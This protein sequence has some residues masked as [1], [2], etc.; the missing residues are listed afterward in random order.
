M[1]YLFDP[2]IKLS[3]FSSVFFKYCFICVTFFFSAPRPEQV[4]AAHDGPITTLQRSPFFRDI[5]LTV[6]GW[7]FAIWKEGVAVQCP[8]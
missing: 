2:Q 3:A 4:W 6:G 7:T 5:I 8:S 1:A